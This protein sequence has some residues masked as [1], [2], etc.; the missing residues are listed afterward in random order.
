MLRIALEL[1]REDQAFDGLATT[2]LEH[3]LSIAEAME[4]FGTDD[5]SLWDEADGFF[6][7]VLVGPDG[8]SEPVRLRSLVGPAA[9]H[10]RGPRTRLDHSRAA[11][12]SWPG[13]AGCSAAGP[14]SPTP[15]VTTRAEGQVVTSLAP[16]TADRA[17][18]L[19]RRLFDEGEFLGPHGI[20][21]LS[22]AYRG[23]VTLDVAGVSMSVAYDP[24]ESTTNLFGGNSNWRGPGVVPDQR[25]AHR[26]AARPCGRRV[27]GRRRGRVPH[28]V[29]AHPR[30][31]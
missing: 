7:D 29:G 3:F 31:G 14:T 13:C 17:D 10:R 11:P 27:G 22:A 12:T 24:G 6:Y 5:V 20:R 1:S 2:F 23:G 19:L 4:T 18:A 15:C 8:H 28:G 26:R 16:L 30:S 25:A 9:A 21:S